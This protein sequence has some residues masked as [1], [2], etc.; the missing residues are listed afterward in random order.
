MKRIITAI[1]IA[2]S[3]LSLAQAPDLMTYQ[4]V[5]WDTGNNLVVNSTVGLQFSIL[6]GSVTGSSVYVETHGPTTNA[7]GLVTTQIGN[8]A[9]VSG[10]FSTIDWS[11]GPYFLKTET[12]PTGGTNYT[13]TGTTQ[14]LSVPYALYANVADSVVNDNVDDADADPVNE[15]N[16]NMTLSGTDL[17]IT[18]AGGTLTA[19]LSSLTGTGTDD[20]T[21]TLSGTDLTIEDGNT[22]DLSV[23]QDGVNDADADPNNELQTISQ[24]GNNLTLSNGGGTVTVPTSLDDDPSNEI[25]TLSVSNDTIYLSNG[26]GNAPLPDPV[27]ENTGG[28][29]SLCSG[30]TPSDGTGWVQFGA[31]GLYIDVDISGCSFAAVPRILTSLEG[32]STHWEL[33][34]VTSIYNATTTG[35]TVYVRFANGAAVSTADADNWDW[36]INWMAI[37]N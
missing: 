10:D 12:D 34:G 18:D 30:N 24:S 9:V 1:T 20:Q 32:T 4:A 17:S 11:T 26:G 8:G 16:T 37:G 15:L 25:Q 22:V 7:N 36:H 23:I 14:L 33:T 29:S 13:I 6:Q 5:V 35:F 2:I 27:V 21:L 19:D 31:N 3:T 28:K